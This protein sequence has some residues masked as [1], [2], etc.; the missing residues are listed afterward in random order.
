VA[1]EVGKQVSGA[2]LVRGQAGDAED[3]D[4]AE[5]FPAGAVAVALD[6][7]HLPDLRPFLQDLPGRRQG[8]DGAHVDPAVAAVDG[9]GLARE[10]PP[11]QRVGGVEQFLLVI[12][13]GEDE[14]GAR[15]LDLLRVLALRVHLVG[16]YD[17]ARQVVSGDLVQEIAEDGDLVCL[18][19]VDGELGGGGAVVPEAGQEH[20][21]GAAAGGAAQGLAVDAQ[22]AAH[23]GAQVTGTG[24]GPGAQGVI[25]LL[26][27]PGVAEDPGERRGVRAAGLPAGGGG[28]A[29]PVQDPGRGRRGPR[30]G[31]L[32]AVVPGRARRHRDRGQVVQGDPPAAVI[33][34]VGHGAQEPAEPCQFRVVPG[35]R[36]VVIG[37]EQFSGGL[38]LRAGHRPGQRAGQ[39]LPPLRGKIGG[40]PGRQDRDRGSR[41]HELRHRRQAGHNRR[42][43]IRDQARTRR[44]HDRLGHAGLP[45]RPVICGRRASLPKE[46]RACSPNAPPASLRC[47]V[48]GVI[49]TRQMSGFPGEHIGR[50]RI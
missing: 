20:R 43:N 36:G 27:V 15:G 30:R 44:G 39:G 31:T 48:P 8:L 16:G 50:T 10:G 7:E 49:K 38:A 33:P 24:G 42:E 41:G 25:D 40:N 13:D 3:G 21:G 22:V 14:V 45:S 26:G 29:E 11:G 6:E 9:P 5:Q 17:G 2:R 37:Q 23:A 1:A 12:A 35:Q 47:R 4:R 32:G 46:P 28:R 19:R 18:F 34:L